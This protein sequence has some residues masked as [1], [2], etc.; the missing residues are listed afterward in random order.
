MTVVRHGVRLYS[1][2]QDGGA[3]VGRACD[4]GRSACSMSVQEM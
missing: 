1:H 2:G 4:N 3:T